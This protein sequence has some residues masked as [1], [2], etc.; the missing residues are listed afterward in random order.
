M[1]VKTK[2]MHDLNSQSLNK[3]ICEFNE[4]IDYISLHKKNFHNRL[5]VTLKKK[6]WDAFHKQ[7][8]IQNIDQIYLILSLPKKK[9]ELIEDFESLCFTYFKKLNLNYSLVII[10]G[11][12]NLYWIVLND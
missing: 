2:N 4:T 12:N 3:L 9:E 11:K 10:P 5:D 1:I 6:F 7:V 8:Y